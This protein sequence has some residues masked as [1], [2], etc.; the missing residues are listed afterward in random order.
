M[1]KYQFEAFMTKYMFDP[2]FRA[3]AEKN[4][5]QAM[6]DLGID[7]TPQVAGA[8]DAFKKSNKLADLKT[9]AN[10]VDRDF[11]GME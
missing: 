5:E 6:Q 3:T 10:A 7:I 8:L 2:A 9:L 4:L 11:T 1:A